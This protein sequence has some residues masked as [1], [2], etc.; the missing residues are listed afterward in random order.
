M[1]YRHV[2]K[3]PLRSN[4]TAGME[5]TKDLKMSFAECQ[6][7]CSCFNMANATLY[8]SLYNDTDARIYLD[9][10]SPSFRPKIIHWADCGSPYSHDTNLSHNP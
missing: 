4:L 6:L 7:F 8:Q 1:K 9:V 2:R 3:P 5:A 10:D